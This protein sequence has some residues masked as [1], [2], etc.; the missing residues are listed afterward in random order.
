MKNSK[1]V[2]FE[3]KISE[4]MSLSRYLEKL[5][6]EGRHHFTTNEIQSTLGMNKN[7]VSASLSRLGK[8]KRVK[9]LRKGFGIILGFGGH[10]PDPSYFIDAMMTHIN[11]KYYVGLLTA[12]SYWGAGHQAV[13]V[14]QVVVDKPVYRVSLEK[15]KIDFVVKTVNFPDKE[16]KRVGGSGGYFKISSPEL[17]AI[18]VVHYA[19]K[20]G[21]LNNVAT[22]L[23]DLSEQL[24]KNAFLQNCQNPSTPTVTLQ[25]IGFVLERILSKKRFAR[26]V[27]QALSNR[28]SV[29]VYLSQAKSK[30]NPRMSD[31]EFDE[32]WK[33]YINTI[34]E[35]D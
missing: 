22:V 13:M 5:I 34:V 6:S 4:K 11:V 31:Y 27:D 10:E 1:K 18:D 25:R 21:Q 30:A 7:T 33:L 2:N 3:L 16:L 8:K 9:M 35:P 20:S 26:I 29:P 23:E 28:R 19:R 15:I 32:H 14:Y 12:A 17:T 24:D